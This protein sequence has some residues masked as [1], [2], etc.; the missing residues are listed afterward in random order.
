MLVCAVP[1]REGGQLRELPIADGWNV[2]DD[3]L[4]ACSPEH[5]DEVF[6]MLA[7]QPQRPHFTGGLEAALITSEIAKRLKE[8]RPRSLFLLMIHRAICLRSLR[9]EKS[10]VKQASLHPIIS[11]NVMFW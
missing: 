7:R 1:K 9:L 2:L 6:T 3:N 11:Y 10:F 8:L 4:L 5:I